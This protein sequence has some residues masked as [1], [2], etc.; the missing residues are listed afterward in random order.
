MPNENSLWMGDLESY[1]TEKFVFQAF[2]QM[3]EAIVKVKLINSKQNKCPA[4]YC[5]VEFSDIES[6]Q[7]AML[8]LNGKIIPGSAPPKRFKLNRACFGR[9]HL[10]VAEYSIF[11]GD[12]SENVD[13]YKLFTIF[14]TRYKSCIA[15]KV[16]L[17]ANGTSRGYG[18]VR[19]TDEAEQQ[20]ALTEMNG[21]TVDDAG[22]PL[23]VSVATPKRSPTSGSGEAAMV[24]NTCYQQQY[25]PSSYY[26]PY[27]GNSS[28][29]AWWMA[30]QQPA[31]AYYYGQPQYGDNTQTGSY[32]YC[33]GQSTTAT[34]QVASMLTEVTDDDEAL[35]EPDTSVDVEQYNSQFIEQSEELYTSL[36]ESRW[37]PLDNLLSTQS[38]TVN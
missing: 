33:D 37:H 1:M 18:F 36:A 3:G 34:T 6:A 32:G 30:Y 15:A 2:E 31:A 14:S 10:A 22:K 8:R 19:F 9:E 13:D 4:G 16:V 17:D 11:V 38:P 27:Y 25:Y 20:R 21:F 26:D 29:A 24:S 5:F 12:I 28:S 23:R 7:R 35:E